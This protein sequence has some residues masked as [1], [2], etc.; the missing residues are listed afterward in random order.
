MNNSITFNI[1][2]LNFSCNSYSYDD[3]SSTYTFDVSSIKET[4]EVIYPFCGSKVHIYDNSVVHLK[5]LPVYSGTFN[6]L[7]VSIHRYRCTSCKSSFSEEIPFKFSGTRITKRLANY[8]KTFLKHH[9]SIKDISDITGVHWDTISKIHKSYMQEALDQRA[10]ELRLADYRPTYLAVDEFAI[11]K[12][13]TYATC[14]MDIETGEVIWVGKG[15]AINDFRKFFNDIPKDYLSEVQTVAMDMNAS[16][17]RLVEEHLP[18]AD[19]VYDRYHFQAQ[20]GKDVLGAVRLEEARIHKEKS[21]ATKDL[22]DSNM[23]KKEVLDLKQKAKNESALYQALK[24]SRWMLL[25][26]GSKLLEDS[27][28]KLN[29]ILESHS[30]IAICYA[31]KEEMTRLF[32]I[33]DIYEAEE[34]WNDWFE[35]AKQS[36]IPQLE[37]FAKLKE[38]RIPGLISHAKHPISTG[39]L[40]GFNNKIKAAKRIGYGY[41]NDNHFFTMIKYLSIPSIRSQ[42]PRN[43]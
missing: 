26:N 30:R 35:A 6:V 12:G 5:D 15:R 17:N 8:I 42:S 32:E 25:K 31:M 22:I 10:E 38:K 3:I 18:S 2:F 16:Y 21:K 9:M 19:I 39:P 7:N 4:Y 34:R 23:S 20:Y 40:E 13:H 11:H 29:T 41:R 33:T 37:K 28:D 43:P 27:M 1:N 24:K 36:G 14:V